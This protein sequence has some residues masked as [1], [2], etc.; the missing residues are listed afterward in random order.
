[1][2][3]LVIVF[4]NVDLLNQVWVNLI[5]NVIKFILDGGY[6]MIKIEC[7]DDQIVVFVNNDGF[8]ILF[9]DQDYLFEKF[10]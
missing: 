3:V 10:Y 5:N 1:M 8:L 2:F 6:L 7:Y 9:I 4:G